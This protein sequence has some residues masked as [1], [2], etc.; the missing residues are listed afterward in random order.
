MKDDG[1]SLKK[2]TI[3][4]PRKIHEALREEAYLRRMPMAQIIIEA[5]TKRVMIYARKE[6]GENKP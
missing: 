2:F 3:M 4:L 6:E 5:L 1:D